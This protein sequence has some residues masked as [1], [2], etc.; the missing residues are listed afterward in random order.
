ML[1]KCL[2]PRKQGFTEVTFDYRTAKYRFE[3]RPDLGISEHIASVPNPDHQTA[4]LRLTK[5]YVPFTDENGEAVRLSDLKQTLER[6]IE[7]PMPPQ[8]LPADQDPT[9]PAP[10]PVAAVADAGAGVVE[11]VAD[12]LAQTTAAGEPSEPEGDPGVA[13]EP[14]KDE[15]PSDEE[16]AAMDRET[17]VALYTNLN[18]GKAPR[19]NAKEDSLRSGVKSLVKIHK[20]ADA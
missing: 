1:I 5:S 3:P 9:G 6:T 11:T 12:A 17:L 13:V 7:P 20:K 2:K 19:S 10:D 8:T 15:Y 16:I 14:A 4:L 18:G